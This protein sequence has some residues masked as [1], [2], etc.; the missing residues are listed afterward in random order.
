M[1]NFF[2][3]WRKRKE[4]KERLE[5]RINTVVRYRYVDRPRIDNHIHTKLAAELRAKS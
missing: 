5:K 2:K 3:Y 4:N 1:L